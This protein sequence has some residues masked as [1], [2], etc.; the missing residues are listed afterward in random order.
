MHQIAQLRSGNVGSN[1]QQTEKLEVQLKTKEETI[2]AL[3]A[4]I[5]GEAKKS[6]Q[7][8]KEKESTIEKLERQ[9]QQA[10]AEQPQHKKGDTAAEEKLQRE[11]RRKDEKVEKLEVQLAEQKKETDRKQ[12][13]VHDNEN[14]LRAK[15]EKINN[16]EKKCLELENKLVCSLFHSL[17]LLILLGRTEQQY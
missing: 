14:A 3:E 9:L 16:L 11:I 6:E 2:S 12:K 10:R 15:T 13:L 4:Q 1:P 8:L 17:F 7:L 5:K